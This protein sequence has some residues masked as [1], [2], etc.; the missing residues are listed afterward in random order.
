MLRCMKGITAFGLAILC[1]ASAFPAYCSA[2]ESDGGRLDLQQTVY[3]EGSYGAYLTENTES[4][5]Q[6]V[7]R[8][9]TVPAASYIAQEAANVQVGEYEGRSGA[10]LWESSEGSVTWNVTVP[11]TGLYYVAVEYCPIQGKG[12]AIDL[13][14]K[15]DG[16]YPF[17]EAA[18][19][20]FPRIWQDDSDHMLMDE[21]G[22]EYTPGVTEVFE[23]SREYFRDGKGSYKNVPYSFYLTEGA[24]TL[25]VVCN[26][27]T[28]ALDS[29]VLLNQEPVPSYAEIAESYKAAG[30]QKS[31]GEMQY[32]QAETPYQK[33]DQTLRAQYDRN[34]PLTQP[35]D[36]SHIRY[37]CIGANAWKYQS[38]WISW[39]IEVPEDGLYHLGARYRQETIKGF[40]SSRRLTI[41]GE[42]PFAEADCIDFAYTED[43]DFLLFGS[44]GEPYLFYLTQGRHV[45]KLEVVM[46]NVSTI[47]GSLQNVNDS[48]MQLYR[49]IITITGTSPD[50][51]RDYSIA[52]SLPDMLPILKEARRILRTEKKNL[53]NITGSK[54]V[55]TSTIQTLLS[56]VENVIETPDSLI[57]SSRLNSFASNISSLSSWLLDLKYQPLTIDY[58]ILKSP[59]DG[60]PRCNANFI[61]NLVSGFQNFLASFIQDYSTSSASGNE[62]ITIWLSVGR[63]QMQIINNIVSDSFTPQYHID[64]DI[65]LVNASLIQ[66]ILAKK[67]PDVAIMV[68]RDQPVNLAVRNGLVDLS[69]LDGFAE[70]KSRFINSATVPYEILGGCYGLPDSLTYNVM[71]C[72]TDI[73]EEM[74]LSVPETWDDLL[75][76]APIMQRN[77]MKIGLGDV[78]PAL[79][80]QKGVTYYNEELTDTN[81]GTPEAYEAFKSWTDYYVLHGFPLEYNF[82]NLFRTGEMPIGIQPYSMYNT[83]RVAAPEIDGLWEMAPLPGTRRSDGTVDRTCAASGTASIIFKNTKKLDASWEFLKWWTSDETQTR[84]SLDMESV[85]GLSARQSTANM[86]TM[87][88]IPWTKNQLSVLKEQMS[89]IQEIPQ[90]PGD[91][92]V[93]R[94]LNNAFNN[95][96]ING[97]NARESLSKW[98]KETSI[99]LERKREEFGLE[100][101]K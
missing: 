41:D 95:T 4:G 58:F 74:N 53:E 100:G 30:Y 17:S 76:L 27:E 61:E 52:E 57:T 81:F 85:L 72:R 3:A 29:I 98:T 2:E 96:V 13:G 49:R 1:L 47:V 37:N 9:I 7:Y 11:E 67:G 64:V 42:L 91:Y 69:A 5:A 88:T 60:L 51:Y 19:T 46:G 80:M 12:S 10:V 25:T 56:Q 23:W 21:N 84:Y 50:P 33:S 32:I 6:P 83:L 22:D 71:F 24:H 92:Y 48:L 14:I 55:N 75:E 31:S 90:V 77:S 89:F 38:Q 68:A 20:T 73:L 101:L 28:F 54:S 66:A 78:F 35:F 45:L 97:E 8:E 43:W 82:Y 16:E 94:N 39:E 86:K 93:T 87:E 26:N 63:D 36:A 18:S 15:I 62:K 99:E 59:D 65:K 79:L 40:A 70:V 44:G 34:S